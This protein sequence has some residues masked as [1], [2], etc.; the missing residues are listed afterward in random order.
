MV[1]IGIAGVA[2]AACAPQPTQLEKYCDVVRQ[3]EATYDPLAHPGA[4]GDP[5]TLRRTLT[6]RVT[7]LSALAAS[8][9]DAVRADATVVRDRVTT[10]VNALAAKSYIA[11]AADV[12]PAVAAVLADAGFADAT[13]RLAA[14]NASS[15]AT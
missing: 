10:V 12:D 2:C 9:P 13:K 7:T 15:C 3:A 8:A 14:F 5:T 11:A 1:A 6:D 4:L